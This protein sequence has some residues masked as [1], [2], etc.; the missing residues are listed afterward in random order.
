MTLSTRPE[1]TLKAGRLGVLGGTFDPI[2]V[3]HVAAA[4]AAAHAL[5]LER[6]VLVPSRLPPHRAE[7]A[8]TSAEHRLAMAALAA[9]AHP[10]WSAS[11]VEVTRDGPSYTFD[12]LNEL[13]RD[14]QPGSQIYFIIG[15]DAFAEI[16]TWSRFPAILDLAHFAVV[17]RPG[18][19]LHSLTARVPDLAERMTTPDQVQPSAIGRQP[20]HGTQ[21]ILIEAATPDVSSTEIRNRVGSGESIRGL[22]PDPVAAYIS[23]HRLYVEASL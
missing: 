7:S 18:I 4:S 20:S 10:H 12:T 2:H 21:I 9:E 15:A 16:A 22:V 6:V 17:A 13:I 23:E 14:G 5:N 1:G 3:G 8:R 11:E 19:T